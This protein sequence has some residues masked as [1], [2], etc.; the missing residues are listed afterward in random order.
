[1]GGAGAPL[2]AEDSIARL[3]RL[4]AGLSKV[5]SGR[6]DAQDGKPIPW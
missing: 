1:M 6:F 4:I 5:D 2:A 3:R